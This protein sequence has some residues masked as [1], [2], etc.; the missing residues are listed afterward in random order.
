MEKGGHLGMCDEPFQYERTATFLLSHGNTK[1]DGS[2]LHTIFCGPFNVPNKE[3]TPTTTIRAR[4]HQ[5]LYPIHLHVSKHETIAKRSQNQHQTP[6]IIHMN[7]VGCTLSRTERTKNHVSQLTRV[8]TREEK[9]GGKTPSGCGARMAKGLMAGSSNWESGWHDFRG[10]V[11][12]LIFHVGSFLRV[13]PDVDGLESSH[14]VDRPI[15]D[16]ARLLQPQT[17]RWSGPGQSLR[18]EKNRDLSTSPKRHPK[19]EMP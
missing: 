14:E 17:M 10:S 9:N 19:A 16:G 11:S 13:P 8:P 18:S 4:T 2:G 3:N 12:A 5:C 7:N 15:N 1:L 6:Q